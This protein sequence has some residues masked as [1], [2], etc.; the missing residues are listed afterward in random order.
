[1]SSPGVTITTREFP[2]PLSIPTDVGQCFMAGTTQ[3][4]PVPS[5]LTVKDQ[6]TNLSDFTKKYNPSGRNDVGWQ[7]ALCGACYWS[8]RC[9]G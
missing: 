7:Q 1:M 3:T 9:Y 5:Q 4:G 2:P 6:C 8:G